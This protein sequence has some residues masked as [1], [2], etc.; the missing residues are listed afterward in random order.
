[1]MRGSDCFAFEAWP[2]EARAYRVV[3]GERVGFVGAR[4]LYRSHGLVVGQHPA[5]VAQRERRGDVGNGG[6]AV[7]LRVTWAPGS[8]DAGSVVPVAHVALRRGRRAAPAAVVERVPPG[9]RVQRVAVDA[10][11]D[12]RTAPAQGP[13]GE[14]GAWRGRIGADRAER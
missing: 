4:S 8:P 7:T 14:H 6:L 3:R 9:S 2:A 10:D 13:A 12:E 11:G 1:M 5:I